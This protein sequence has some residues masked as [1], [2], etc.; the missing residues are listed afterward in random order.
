MRAKIT[1][2]T[3]NLG[4]SDV[5]A[6]RCQKASGAVFMAGIFGGATL[7]FLFKSDGHRVVRQEHIV[8]GPGHMGGI[9]GDRE[10]VVFMRSPGPGM[11]GDELDLND[12]QQD[13]VERLMEEQREK[14]LALLDR[15]GMTA[16]TVSVT[17]PFQFTV[18][19]PVIRLVQQD[20][21]TGQGT[22]NMSASATMR[23]E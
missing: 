18:L 13:R 9:P 1:R 16:S 2:R 19:N 10:G 3:Q 15:H 8:A 23:N 5:S 14:A 12:E 7:F 21:T 20:S 22:T 11:F 6:R 4:D 17:Y